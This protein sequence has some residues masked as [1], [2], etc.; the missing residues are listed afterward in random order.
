MNKLVKYLLIGG[1]VCALIEL[2]DNTAKAITLDC[3]RTYDKYVYEDMLEDLESDDN[4][5]SSVFQI[6]RCKR[7]AKIARF[8]RDEEILFKME[9]EA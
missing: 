5:G 2:I 3:V 8:C 6:A 7:I 4:S 1:G 9:E